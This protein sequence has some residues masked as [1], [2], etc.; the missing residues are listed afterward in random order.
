MSFMELLD[1]TLNSESLGYGIDKNI[2]NFFRNKKMLLI[3]DDFDVFY[4][5]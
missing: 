2:K 5:E 3:F 1:K 4:S